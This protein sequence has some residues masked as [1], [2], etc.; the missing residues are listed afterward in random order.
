MNSATA[1]TPN[2][3]PTTDPK[4]A[5]AAYETAVRLIADEIT[6]P[7]RHAGL[8]PSESYPV[9]P[10][11]SFNTLAQLRKSADVSDDTARTAILHAVR[12]FHGV[13]TGLI[14]S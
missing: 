4:K 2:A 10:M 5:R 14:L 9:E 1:M 12:A 7:R 6:K 13:G 11:D 3:E 8:E